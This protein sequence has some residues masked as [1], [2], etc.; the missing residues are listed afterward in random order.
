MRP[1]F[2]SSNVSR[3]G[4]ERGRP[5]RK[6]LAEV[7]R[8]EHHNS[9][10]QM[11]RLLHQRLRFSKLALLQIKGPCEVLTCLGFVTRLA[12]SAAVLYHTE[13]DDPAIAC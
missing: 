13:L 10:H 9:T 1:S 12:C 3:R 6:R 7:C 2:T 4:W 5:L 8:A 11:S